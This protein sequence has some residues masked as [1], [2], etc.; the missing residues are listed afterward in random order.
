MK[1]EARTPVLVLRVTAEACGAKSSR[2]LVGR[3]KPA[4]PKAARGQSTRGSL[5]RKGSWGCRGS[6]EES[7]GAHL[8]VSHEE[9]CGA[10]AAGCWRCEEA[11]G[12]KAVGRQWIDRQGATPR[13]ARVRGSSAFKN[14]EARHASHMHLERAAV[15]FAS[16][17]GEWRPDGRGRE[18]RLSVPELNKPRLSSAPP[19]CAL[20]GSGLQVR[21]EEHMHVAVADMAYVPVLFFP[22]RISQT[23]CRLDDVV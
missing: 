5:R 10:K 4:A 12:A 20:K 6:R 15:I 21:G 1:L 16:S 9:A 11:C 22:A 13:Q 7:C 19:A 3:R 17:I 23:I 8:M 18:S 14:A 2:V